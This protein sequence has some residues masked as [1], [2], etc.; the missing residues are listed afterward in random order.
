MEFI[1]PHNG[2][3]LVYDPVNKEVQLRPFG[4][5]KSL[6]MR[7][8]PQDRLVKSSGGHTVDESDLGA[9]F[10][11]VVALQKGGKTIVSGEEEVGGR[12]TIV[13]SVEG[14]QNA[15]VDGFH[16]YLLWL[17]IKSYLPL[18]VISYDLRGRKLEEVAMTDL[19]VDVRF[20]E[21]FFSL[22]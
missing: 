2:A 15:E 1:E 7:L 4:F 11:R 9:L 16:R 14:A 3:V 6:V 12:K 22:E 18:K 5:L 21:G 20:P 13:V 8:S 10:K 19:E 17:D